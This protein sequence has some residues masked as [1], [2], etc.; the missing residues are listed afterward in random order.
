MSFTGNPTTPG[1]PYVLAGTTTV[2]STMNNN[3]VAATFTG[4]DPFTAVQSQVASMVLQF[5]DIVSNTN[6]SRGTYVDNNIYA[7]TDSPI[8][9]SNINGN[10]LALPPNSTSTT[11]SPSLGMVTS[12]TVPGAADALFQAAGAT[13]CACQYLQWGYWTGQVQ[14]T[15]SQGLGVNRTDRAYIN[16]WWPGSRQSPCQL[17]V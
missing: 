6:S 14:S 15:T 16:T 3:R 9:A 12:A 1:N 8:T 4:S 11:P 5:G 10:P 7:A 17:A 13:P 2:S